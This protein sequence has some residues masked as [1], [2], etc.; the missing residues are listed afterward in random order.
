M[1]HGLCGMTRRPGIVKHEGCADALAPPGP[2]RKNRTNGMPAPTNRQLVS[3]ND[4]V[5]D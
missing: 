3:T 4:T 1:F 5:A 2:A